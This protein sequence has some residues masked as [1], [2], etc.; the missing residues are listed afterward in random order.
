M[1]SNPR[2]IHE[3]SNIIQIKQSRPTTTT[4]QHIA[5]E[6]S[7]NQNVF[8]PS[9]SSPPNDFMMK[10]YAR[11]NMYNNYADKRVEILDRE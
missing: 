3:R 11:M 2:T 10:L 4:K 9:K 1:L 5:E 7:L 8:D 6:Y